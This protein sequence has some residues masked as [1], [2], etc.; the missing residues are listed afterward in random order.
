MDSSKDLI[1]QALLAQYTD[2]ATLLNGNLPGRLPMNYDTPVLAAFQGVGGSR[3]AGTNMVY[4]K[5]PVSDRPN[6]TFVHIYGGSAHSI[7][8]CQGWSL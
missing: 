6:S 5:G 4:N 1:R 2:S 3:A 7:N 8:N